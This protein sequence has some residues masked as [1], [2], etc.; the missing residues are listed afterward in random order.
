MN[1]DLDT[2]SAEWLK[3]KEDEK[4]ATERRRELE[5]HLLSLIGIPENLEGVE[6]VETDKGHKIKITGRMSR[7]VDGEKLQEIAAEAGLTDHLPRLFRWKPEIN[8]AA[9]KG[10]AKSI[11]D[12]LLAAVTTKTG[13]PSF[14][15]IIEE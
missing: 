12:R 9:W 4:A 14:I 6:N 3:A 13:R 11:T 2:A 10:T 7:K 15:I 8:L 1:L 5:D